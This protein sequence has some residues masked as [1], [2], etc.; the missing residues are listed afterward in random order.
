MS[1]TIP[2]NTNRNRNSVVL[3]MNIVRIVAGITTVDSIFEPRE[4]PSSYDTFYPF[5]LS[6]MDAKNI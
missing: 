5:F 4:G 1:R 6:I 3:C 2:I